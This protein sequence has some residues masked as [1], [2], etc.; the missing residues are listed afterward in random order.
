MLAHHT[1]RPTLTQRVGQHRSV[2]QADR[3]LGGWGVLLEVRL[4]QRDFTFVKT[5]IQGLPWWLSGKESTCQCRR[6]RFDP[7]VMKIP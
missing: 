6:H 4:S 1:D 3:K 7:W 2:P 5:V